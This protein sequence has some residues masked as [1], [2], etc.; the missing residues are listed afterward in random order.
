MTTNK[1][2]AEAAEQKS[3]DRIG[4]HVAKL[5][6]KRIEVGLRLRV[7]QIDTIDTVNQ[8]YRVRC[9]IDMDWLASSR[10]TANAKEDRKGFVP[11]HIPRIEPR[12][13]ID[14]ENVDKQWGNGNLYKLVEKDG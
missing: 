14:G 9:T 1:E 11:E 4:S 2:L 12:N 6:L 13:I 8:V 3:I 7:D 10:D 5:D